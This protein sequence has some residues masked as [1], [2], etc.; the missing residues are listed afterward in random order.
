M[1]KVTKTIF[2]SVAILLG[3][4][5]W[6]QSTTAKSVI[7][8]KELL[9]G[10]VDTSAAVQLAGRV[11]D[12]SIDYVVEPKPFLKFGVRDPGVEHGSAIQVV[13]EGI[14]PDTLKVGRD[15]IL[16]G[17]YEGER[18]VASSLLTQCPSKY[19]PPQLD[20]ELQLKDNDAA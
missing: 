8:V 18:F 3:V 2:C 15:V 11:T 9:A 13:Y 16:Q 20:S 17:R 19:E 5:F 12:N 14:M 1:N 6:V 10:E 4:L 7:T